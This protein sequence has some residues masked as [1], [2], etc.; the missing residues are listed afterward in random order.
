MNDK[1]ELAVKAHKKR[2][3]RN[4]RR[5]ESAQEICSILQV[6]PLF[7][8]ARIALKAEKQGELKTAQSCWSEIQSY[9]APKYKAV[10]PAQQIEKAA[11]AADLAELQKIKQAIL[12]GTIIDT[13]YSE[14]PALPAPDGI[15]DTD[16]FS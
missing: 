15:N 4:L 14:S 12:S 10:D 8:I 16:F 3:T 5:L 9:M 6:N 2:L 11:K 1:Q 13:E 7:E